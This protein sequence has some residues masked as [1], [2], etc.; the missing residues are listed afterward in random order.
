MKAVDQLPL[1]PLIP[2]EALGGR[3]DRLAESIAND[4][5]DSDFL[6][7]SI[8]KGSFMF[9]ADL[10]RGLAERGCHPVV[11]FMMLSSYGG[12]T[13]SS[14]QITLLLQ[15]ALPLAG[16]RILL[17]DD[18][19]DTGHTLQAATS[20]LLAAGAATVRTCVLL[21]KPSRREVRIEADYVGFPIGNV[22]VVGY[23]LD[24]DHHYR[25]LPYIAAL[26]A[27]GAE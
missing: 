4:C 9:T 22:F 11:D 20:L 25:G 2:R 7:L 18:I 14:R 16:R 21:D 15:P 3:I 6:L 13:R 19:L 23:G 26:P 12:G 10:C 27:P 5:A 17:V 8:L 24:Y 1:T